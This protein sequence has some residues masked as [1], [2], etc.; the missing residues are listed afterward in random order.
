DE[1]RVLRVAFV[2]PALCG[3]GVEIAHRL[4]V[5]LDRLAG[6]S[7]THPGDSGE[8]HGRRDQV[9][10]GCE[11]AR[12]ALGPPLLLDRRERILELWTQTACFEWPSSTQR[13]AAAA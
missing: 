12:R 3:G 7:H 5:A 6:D 4:G 2:D 10:P 8:G 13:C 9:R 1:D 11:D